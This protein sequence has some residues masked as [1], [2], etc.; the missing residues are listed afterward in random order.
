MFEKFTEGG[1]MLVQTLQNREQG[2]HHPNSRD[3][4]YVPTAL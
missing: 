2:S 3:L 1:I 4:E